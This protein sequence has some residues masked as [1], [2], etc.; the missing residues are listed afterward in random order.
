MIKIS[1][2]KYLEYKEYIIPYITYIIPY[3]L[4]PI[5]VI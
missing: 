2:R 1:N 5:S 3:V 4:I